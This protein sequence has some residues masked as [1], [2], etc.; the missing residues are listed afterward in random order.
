MSNYKETRPWGNFENLL[1][2]DSCKVKKISIVSLLCQSKGAIIIRRPFVKKIKLYQ[3]FF[4]L[5]RNSV[6][7][8]P[9]W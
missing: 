8:L 7:S 9:K 1:E 2:E 5:K 6:S 4:S 3:I